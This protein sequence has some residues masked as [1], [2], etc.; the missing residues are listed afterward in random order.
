MI[1]LAYLTLFQPLTKA[2][3]LE[4]HTLSK[5]IM[6][7]IGIAIAG[8]V[9][10]TLIE[11]HIFNLEAVS[12]IILFWLIIWIIAGTQ[13][14]KAYLGILKNALKTKLLN[15]GTLNLTKDELKLLKEVKPTSSSSQILCCDS[16]SSKGMSA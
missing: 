1:S 5:G 2:K 7:P 16:S 9:L 8:I 10:Y 6:E 15:R 3:R 4:G 13:L 11:S 14:Y 12:Y